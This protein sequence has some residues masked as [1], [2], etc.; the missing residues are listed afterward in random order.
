MRKRTNSVGDSAAN[1][2]RRSNRCVGHRSTS[3][4]AE[5]LSIQ[6][7]V[8]T[9]SLQ[10][11]RVGTALDDAPGIDHQNLIGSQNSRKAMCNGH[12]GSASLQLFE[13]SLD[14][15]FGL[16][17]QR[18]RRLIQ[19]KDAWILQQDTGDGNALLLAAGE[20]VTACPTIVSYPLGSSIILSCICAAVAAAMIS[21][22][23]ACGFP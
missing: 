7:G 22:S 10:K 12:G 14:Q 19:H 23:V 11:Q 9:S 15:A 20:G 4:T 13:C 5:L 18:A 16:R 21:A 6:P 17:V 8:Q 3:R 1:G 2:L